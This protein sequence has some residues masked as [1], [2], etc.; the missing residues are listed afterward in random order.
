VSGTSGADRPPSLGT[1]DP[2][3]EDLLI[4]TQHESLQE[5]M[6]TGAEDCHSLVLLVSLLFFL[7]LS[8]FVRDDWVS[9][10]FVA[11][12]MY[13]VLI[14]AI[15]K[16]SEKRSMPW[17]ALLLTAS[18]L[19]VTLVCVFRPVHILQI[20]NWMFLST[21][22]GYVSVALFAFLERS[23]AITKGKLFASLG[24][25]L[26][27]GMFYYAVF[28]LIEVIHQGSFMEVGRTPRMPSRHSLLYLSLA[29]L[30]TV[31]YGDVL[32]V[33]RPARMIAVLEAATGVFYIAITVARLVAAYKQPHGNGG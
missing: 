12:S 18:S 33:S 13:A 17:P 6:K 20:A 10:V 19:L 3:A 14:I 32:P 22:F 29:T 1:I 26:I 11:L 16:I 28:N 30:T 7:V 27:L 4:T 5:I 25:Y 8:A 9:E 31:G 21:F 15:L 23:G 24:L 2:G